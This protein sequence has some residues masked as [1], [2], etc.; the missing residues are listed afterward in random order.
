MHQR[1]TFQFWKTLTHY[2]LSFSLL[3]PS[4]MPLRCQFNLIILTIPCFITLLSHF[5]S[6]C[7]L[8]LHSGVIFSA[9]SSN[10][11]N[12]PFSCVFVFNPLSFHFSDNI[13]FFFFCQAAC[14]ILVLQSVT[15]PGPLAVTTQSP[16]PWTT[17]EFLRQ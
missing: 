3:A 6:V 4:G 11:V 10:Y 1:A 15:E 17:G 7:L 13:F 16:S 5:P 12:P 14:G 8:V 9:L 2:R